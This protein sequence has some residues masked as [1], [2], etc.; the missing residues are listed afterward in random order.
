[1]RVLCGGAPAYGGPAP[2][3]AWAGLRRRGNQ[4]RRAAPAI[5]SPCQPAARLCRACLSPT[6]PVWWRRP[7]SERR[8]VAPFGDASWCEHAS[9]AATRLGASGPPAQST[10]PGDRRRERA[11]G[12]S[13]TGHRHA[14]RPFLG[15]Y[16][17]RRSPGMTKRPLIH[18]HSD[19]A[20]N[21]STE[22][23]LLSCVASDS[24]PASS[25]SSTGITWIR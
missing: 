22:R 3:S 12:G 24:G 14:L 8:Q 7:A 4:L 13:G 25:S 11:P 9:E 17:D 1:V 2:A 19:P 23:V 10:R 6:P 20:T 15:A 16:R 21:L 5:G 18:G